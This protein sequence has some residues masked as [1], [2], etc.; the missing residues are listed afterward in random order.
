VVSDIDQ[1][2]EAMD[3]A[4]RRAACGPCEVQ[5]C[6]ESMQRKQHWSIL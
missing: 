1:I 6:R 3:E 5:G 4:E 2:Y